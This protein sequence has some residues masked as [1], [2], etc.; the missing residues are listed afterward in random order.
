[1]SQTNSIPNSDAQSTGLPVGAKVSNAELELG[2]INLISQLEM[3]I[4]SAKS[5]SNHVENASSNTDKLLSV[6]LDFCEEYLDES[7][8][9]GPMKQIQ[10]AGFASL[11]H[12][13]VLGSLGWGFA[14]SNLFGKSAG[15]DE[16]VQET[17]GKLGDD[18]L[19]ACV[20]V[21]QQAVDAVGADS[22]TGKTIEQSAA[23]FVE[24]FKANW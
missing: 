4:D 19:C 13:E 20:A 22:E 6:L 2:C 10:K 5:S 3:Q 12:K 21:L 11:A 7:A 23:V 16:R 18:L 17:Y 14:I 8:T 1:M 9:A 15:T 24:E